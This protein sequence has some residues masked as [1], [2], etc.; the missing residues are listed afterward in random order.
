MRGTLGDLRFVGD[1]QVLNQLKAAVR[2]LDDGKPFN[3]LSIS[4]DQPTAVES[5]SSTH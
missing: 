5:A 4:D 1:R 3:I 2:K